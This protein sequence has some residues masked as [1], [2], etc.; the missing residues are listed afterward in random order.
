MA[1]PAAA[2]LAELVQRRGLERAEEA[3]LS[4]D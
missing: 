1:N 4:V 2:A 3:L